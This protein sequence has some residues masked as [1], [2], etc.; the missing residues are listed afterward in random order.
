[1][2]ILRHFVIRL[3]QISLQIKT[4]LRIFS[5]LENF[6][7]VNSYS[8]ENKVKHQQISFCKFL[9]CIQQENAPM[10]TRFPL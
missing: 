7:S 1:M 10:E 4:T 8:W 3:I 2:Y 6:R 9:F 5:K